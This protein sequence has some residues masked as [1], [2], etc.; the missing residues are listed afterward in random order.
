ML[1]SLSPTSYKWQALKLRHFVAS[2]RLFFSQFFLQGFLCKNIPFFCKRNSCMTFKQLGQNAYRWCKVQMQTSKVE[3]IL[4]FFAPGNRGSESKRRKLC[5]S[6]FQIAQ[7]RTLPMQNISAK[8]F[9]SSHPCSTITPA[10]RSLCVFL[11]KDSF[12]V[13][14]SLFRRQFL[15]PLLFPLPP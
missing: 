6:G 3:K 14:I 5:H 1:M 10:L 15:F 9:P 12:S 2:T 11:T 4:F 8:L 13:D 7:N